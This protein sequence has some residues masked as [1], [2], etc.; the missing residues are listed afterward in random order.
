MDEG[1]ND[2]K[3]EYMKQVMNMNIFFSTP[4]TRHIRMEFNLIAPFWTTTDPETQK[5]FLFLDS[6]QLQMLLPNVF[7]IHLISDEW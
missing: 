4:K 6:D 2:Q 1:N 7:S 3:D 5:T